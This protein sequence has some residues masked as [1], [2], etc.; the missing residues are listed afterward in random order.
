LEECGTAAVST[1]G[2]ARAALFLR[3][4]VK[5][6]GKYHGPRHIK[7]GWEEWHDTQLS[8]KSMKEEG[9]SQVEERDTAGGDSPSAA[10][11]GGG[12]Q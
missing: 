11:G 12:K 5:E 6:A 2:K 10:T 4:P 1:S 7:K 8:K 3:Q 9:M